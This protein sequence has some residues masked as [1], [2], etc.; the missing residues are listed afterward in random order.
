MLCSSFSRD[1]TG[2]QSIWNFNKLQEF[3]IFSFKFYKTQIPNIQKWHKNYDKLGGICDMTLLYYYVH[4]QTEFKGLQLPNFP[5]I[6]N[7]LTEIFNNEI[8][9]DVHLATHGNHL[10]PNDYE[11]NT[12][13]N[14][15]NIKYVN[16]KPVCHNKRLNKDIKF[17]LLHFQ[18][19]NKR[20]MKDFYFKNKLKVRIN[21]KY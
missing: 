5:T 9:F 17:V 11:I 2:G 13:T 21:I 20:F 18:G 1:V 7:D 4:N 12:Q 16:N 19:N 3:T 6:D 14:N 15:K 8:T 10:Y